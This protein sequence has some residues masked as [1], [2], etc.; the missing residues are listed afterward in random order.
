MSSLV[1]NSTAEIVQLGTLSQAV[2]QQITQAVSGS[3]AS[4]TAAAGSATAASGSATNAGASATSAAASAASA[5]ASATSA[6]SS[7]SAASA[8]AANAA[9]AVSSA[10]AALLPQNLLT[11][12]Y[13]SSFQLV[14]A[15]RDVNE[16][17]VTASIVW[18]DGGTG[19]FTT[20]TAS[21]SFPGAIDAWH[22]TYVN[23]SANHTVTQTLVTRDANGAVIAQPAI[24]IT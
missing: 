12:A 4:A 23:G 11:W 3:A 9:S 5:S 13:A 10:L 15:T 2:S 6:T 7:A 17:I 8:S 22:A 19:A 18:P 20:D 21:T 1:I 24:T 16:A 14:S